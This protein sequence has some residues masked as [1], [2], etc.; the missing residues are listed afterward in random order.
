MQEQL[1]AIIQ[2]I[3]II[4][5]AIKEGRAGKEAILDVQMSV[6]EVNRI[7]YH[8]SQL[9][10]QKD[11]DLNL[12]ESDLE[13]INEAELLLDIWEQSLHRRAGTRT[14]AEFWDIYEYFK[15]V[16]INDIFQETLQK[17][18]ALPEGLRIE[19][20]ALPYRYTFLKN[21]IDYSCNDFSL[22]AQ[23][24]EL[25][26]NGIE[27]YKWLYERLADNRSK[28]ILNGIIRYWFE[29]DLNKLSALCETTFSDYYD[30]DILECG[31]NDVIVD[32]GAYTGD[33][34][35]DYIYTYGKYQRIYAYEITPCTYQT[36]LQN[37]S[38]YQN[39]I[40]LQKGVGSQKG[41]MFLDEDKQRGGNHLLDEGEIP[42]EV[43][44]L[45]EDIKEPV[46]VIKMD[47]EGAE[48]DAI[49]GAES[50]IRKEKPKLLIS[51]YHIPEDIFEIPQLIHS[52]RGDYK[53]YMR[54]YGHGC[55][56][57]CDYVLFAV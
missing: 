21:K 1:S 9:K 22:I 7:L 20:F 51:S 12:V 39:I 52:I 11:Y 16:D 25:M 13:Y 48:K 53:F 19:Y 44:T 6:G 38:E 23:H 2:N 34:I 50:H 4:L 5:R 45:D 37:I 27:K 57:P 32:L 35:L 10:F 33:S 29:F 47:I 36:L 31:E 42:V 17:F 14:D 49:L 30:M 24:V 8:V 41:K 28:M 43:V 46:T 3:K 15:Y 26:V 40:P 55:L 54:F 18:M 56:W